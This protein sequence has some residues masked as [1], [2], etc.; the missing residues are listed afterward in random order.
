MATNCENYLNCK[1]IPIIG[2]CGTIDDINDE[3]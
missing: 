2:S 1:I 3:D